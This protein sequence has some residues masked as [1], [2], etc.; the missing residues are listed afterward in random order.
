MFSVVLICMSMSGICRSVNHVQAGEDWPGALE[1]EFVTASG[2][3]ETLVT[4]DPTDVRPAG[5][6]DLVAVRPYSR[7][8]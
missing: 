8:A 3:T 6:A 4:L 5:D 7:M 2:K 1:V